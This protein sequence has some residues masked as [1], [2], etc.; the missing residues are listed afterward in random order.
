MAGLPG[1]GKS[2][3]AR[4]LAA[5]LGAM[6]L[7]KDEVRACLFGTVLRDH[8]ADR[9]D[10]CVDV[11]YRTAE[12]TLRRDPER[13]V[14]LDGRTYTRAVQVARLREVAGDI[15]VPL[16]IIECVCAHD[17]AVARIDRDRAAGR[18][19][20]ADRDATL[21]DT[22]RRGAE[23]IDGP[24]LVVDTGRPLDECVAYCLRDL[25]G[26]EPPG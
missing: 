9:N 20:A 7:D 3:L 11:M 6:L 23:P 21:H 5:P 17:M 12:W 2:T 19:P 22:L 10:F 24:K 25:V 1:A 16:R 15:G 14:I 4:T 8:G 13:H 18:H 26:A